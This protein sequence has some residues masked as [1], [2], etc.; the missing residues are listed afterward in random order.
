MPYFVNLYF[1]VYSY[2]NQSCLFS[3]T[4][5]YIGVSRASVLGCNAI[6][7][8]QCILGKNHSNNLD[9]KND[10]TLFAFHWFN[11][12][13]SVLKTFEPL[14]PLILS[15]VLCLALW[16]MTPIIVAHDLPS[17]CGNIKNHLIVNVVAMAKPN[18]KSK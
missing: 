3:F 9:Y 5:S 10:H 16:S 1:C 18:Q 15:C 11:L 7:C 17:T 8:S 6:N 2:Y 4:T 14:T 12:I 13:F